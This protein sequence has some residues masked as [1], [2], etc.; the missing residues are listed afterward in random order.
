MA[1]FKQ[2]KKNLAGNSHQPEIPLEEIDGV[3]HLMLQGKNGPQQTVPSNHEKEQAGGRGWLN[4]ILML[5]WKRLASVALFSFV[6]VAAVSFALLWQFE[7]NVVS[8]QQTGE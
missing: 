2:K 7:D 8:R 5:N 4:S 6:C 1:L 3:S